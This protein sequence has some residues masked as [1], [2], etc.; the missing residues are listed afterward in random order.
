MRV[1]LFRHPAFSLLVHCA[2][3]SLYPVDQACGG[4]RK[5]FPIS[6]KPLGSVIRREFYG[7]HDMPECWRRSRVSDAATSA[8]IIPALDIFH[9]ALKGRVS[10]GNQARRNLR[11][12]ALPFAGGSKNPHPPVSRCDTCLYCFFRHA[13]LGVCDRNGASANARIIYTVLMH[14]TTQNFIEFVKARNKRK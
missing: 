11:L 6:C 7:L 9:H 13:R 10:V 12:A 8:S 2:G 1:W 3:P 4:A 14:L 5:R